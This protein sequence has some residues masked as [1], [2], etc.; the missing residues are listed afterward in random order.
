MIQNFLRI[1]RDL[2]IFNEYELFNF[3]IVTL[4]F[5]NLLY[6]RSFFCEKFKIKQYIS[7]KKVL[8]EIGKEVIWESRSP[9]FFLNVAVERL[10]KL[11]SFT[12]IVEAY[13]TCSNKG[14]DFEGRSWNFGPSLAPDGTFALRSIP[15]CTEGSIPYAPRVM[16]LSVYS[17]SWQFSPI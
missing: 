16:T 3:F 8:C 1:G 10:K 17:F 6:P 9:C 4:N 11:Y 14:I 12:E 2:W 5:T 13:K 15:E 7:S